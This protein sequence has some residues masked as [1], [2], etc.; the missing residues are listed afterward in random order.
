MRAL[1]VVIVI[2]GVLIVAGTVVIAV[3]IANRMGTRAPPPPL[4][5]L[6]EPAGSRIVGIA[7]A[8]ERLA[9]HVSGGGAEDRIVIVD[10]TTHRVIGRL[11]PVSP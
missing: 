7:A 11:V 6:G 3:T 8:G 5:G 9:V 1:K 2:M 4:A 10:P